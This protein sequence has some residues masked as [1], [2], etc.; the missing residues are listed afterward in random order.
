MNAGQ[1][2]RVKRLEKALFASADV[3]ISKVYGNFYGPKVWPKIRVA[4]Q[5][6]ERTLKISTSFFKN[7]IGTAPRFDMEQSLL[8]SFDSLDANFDE[9]RRDFE[10]VS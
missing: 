9:L 7:D 5:Q 3:F 6:P 4:L 8:Q 2:Y 1:T 10:L